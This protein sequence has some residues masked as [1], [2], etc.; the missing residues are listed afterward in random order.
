MDVKT[1]LCAYWATFVSNPAIINPRTSESEK[2][3]VKNK[4]LYQHFVFRVYPIT[5][6]V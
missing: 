5:E 1:T 2:D 4:N 3:L 6:Q